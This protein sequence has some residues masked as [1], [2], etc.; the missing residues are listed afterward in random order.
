MCAAMGESSSWKRYEQPAIVDHGGLRDLTA[1]THPLF[2][3]AGDHGAAS[4]DLAFSGGQGG[5]GQG[6][7]HGGQGGGHGP[8]GHG[9]GGHGPHGH[10]GP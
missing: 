4:Q 5:G 7:G 10:H 9:G 3:G 1:V 2:S 6:G 8:G